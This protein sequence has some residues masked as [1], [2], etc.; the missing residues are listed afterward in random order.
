MTNIKIDKTF[1]D[2]AKMKSDKTTLEAL[3]TA[4]DNTIQNVDEVIAQIAYTDYQ[5]KNPNVDF[6]DFIK[7]FQPNNRFAS[8]DS[9]KKTYADDEELQKKSP[10]QVADAMYQ[11]LSARTNLFQ[12]FRNINYKDYKDFVFQ[13]APRFRDAL[14]SEMLYKRGSQFIKGTDPEDLT[15]VPI[16]YTAR[17]LQVLSGSAT[18]NE[19]GAIQ[20]TSERAAISLAV[21]EQDANKFLKNSLINKFETLNISLDREDQ[22]ILAGPVTNNQGE[23]VTDLFANLI[24]TNPKTQQLEF[25]NPRLKKYQ[26]M[27]EIC[28]L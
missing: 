17:E 16:P 8:V 13:N 26:P 15:K 23:Q 14:P 4:A 3:E 25:Y 7:V 27:T 2:Y 5:T 22:D 11:E 19:P 28:K 10:A 24:T 9:Y 21:T 20:L 6:I 18:G 12:A 1:D